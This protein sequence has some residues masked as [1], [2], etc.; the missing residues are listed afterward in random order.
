MGVVPLVLLMAASGFLMGL[1]MPSRDMLVR[2]AAPPGQAGTVFG[3]VSTGFNLGGMVGP[4]GWGWLL[5]SG[6]PQLVFVGA[7]AMIGVAVVVSLLQE[8]GRVRRVGMAA[9]E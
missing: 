7:A 9:A 1:I 5:D 6:R 2:A 4:P 3:V 8:R